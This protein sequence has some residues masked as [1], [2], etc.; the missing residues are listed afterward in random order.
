MQGRFHR[1]TQFIP[2]SDRRSN[3]ERAPAGLMWGAPGQGGDRE[4]LRPPC[5]GQGTS[6]PQ[7]LLGRVR[8]YSHPAARTGDSNPPGVQIEM[9][10]GDTTK[11]FKSPH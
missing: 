6:F 11:E 3:S 2:V 7:S 9:S 8:P 10:E 5:L 4:E 1:S